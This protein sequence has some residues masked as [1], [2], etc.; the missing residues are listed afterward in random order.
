VRR[1]AISLGYGRSFLSNAVRGQIA[2]GY[3]M[4]DGSAVD[5]FEFAVGL[6]LAL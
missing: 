3:V 6:V 4:G 1:T 2:A 5:G